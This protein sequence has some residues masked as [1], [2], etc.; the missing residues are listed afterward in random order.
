MTW[1]EVVAWIVVGSFLIAITGSLGYYYGRESYTQ[2][3]KA[4]EVIYFYKVTGERYK[5]L[6]Q[7][8]CAQTEYANR[9]WWAINEANKILMIEN[10]KL[11][12]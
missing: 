5:A 8:Q 7:S 11:K 9:K 6:Y 1:K 4:G 2:D 10:N 12:R 3:N